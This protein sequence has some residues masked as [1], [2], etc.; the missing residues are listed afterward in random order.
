MNDVDPV[1]KHVLRMIDVG[2]T[3]RT[4]SQASGVPFGTIENILRQSVQVTDRTFNA[5]MA[6]EIRPPWETP[7]VVLHPRSKVPG[8][9]TARRL[10]ALAR[11]GYPVRKIS[12][13][14]GLSDFRLRVLIKS[15]HISIE[16]R[17]A[18][19]V[20]GFYRQALLREPD[21]R[22]RERTRRWAESQG[23]EG[24]GVWDDIDRDE[25]P[26][27]PG[28]LG[29]LIDYIEENP[30]FTETRIPV[31]ISADLGMPIVLAY[32][33]IKEA[34][35]SGELIKIRRGH[36]VRVYTSDWKEGDLNGEENEGYEVRETAVSR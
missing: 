4:V 10:Q 28:D 34:L 1:R 19:L 2:H 27:R 3:Q 25:R 11:M 6:V 9:G 15:P 29:V 13:K 30:G 33:L 14:T 17:T 31:L 20:R 26:A 18:D 32:N 8:L 23:W 12:E 5:I 36:T 21:G 35:E 7:G 22:F 24:P 16:L